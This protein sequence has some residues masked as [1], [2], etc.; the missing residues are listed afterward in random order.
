MRTGGCLCGAVRYTV[1]RRAVPRRT[2]PLRRLPE[3]VGQRVHH[4][5]AVAAERVRVDRRVRDLRRR[6]LLSPLRLA[7]VPPRRGGRRDPARLARRGAV[8]AAAGSG[9][10]DQ[11]PRA[12]DATARRRRAA[13]GE[14]ALVVGQ[15]L[16]E[17]EVAPLAVDAEGSAGRG[18]FARSR[19]SRARAVTGGCRR[20]SPPRRGAARARRTRTRGSRRPRRLRARVRCARGRPSSRPFRTAAPPGG[21]WKRLIVPA[22]ASPSRIANAGSRRSRAPRSA[23]ADPRR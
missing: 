17:D 9:A 11:A 2:L 18:R 20:A 15:P 12:V 19:S 7:P 22:I 21:S 23:A 14:P 4:L 10:L 5:R 13:R 1:A 16:E 8:R 3:A 6:Q